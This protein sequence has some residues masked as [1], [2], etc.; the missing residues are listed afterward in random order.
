MEIVNV[1]L[2]ELKL[3]KIKEETPIFVTHSME[4]IQIFNLIRE[5]KNNIVMLENCSNEL[6]NDVIFFKSLHSILYIYNDLDIDFV[7][8]MSDDLKND[9][10]LFLYMLNRMKILDFRL[11]LNLFDIAKND[12]KNDKDVIL[13]ILEIDPYLYIKKSDDKKTNIG[14]Y[15]YTSENRFDEDSILIKWKKDLDILKL[16]LKKKIDLSEILT[17]EELDSS[18]LWLDLLNISQENERKIILSEY[19]KKEWLINGNVETRF[20]DNDINNNIYLNNII[21]KVEGKGFLIKELSKKECLGIDTIYHIIKNSDKYM[22]KKIIEAIPSYPKRRFFES[23]ITS[24]KDLRSDNYNKTMEDKD[25]VILKKVY[26]KQEEAFFKEEINKV[27]EKRGKKD[28]F[29]PFLLLREESD[30]LDLYRKE[31][32]KVLVDPKEMK[33]I[34]N[35]VE[36]FFLGLKKEVEDLES[37][38]KLQEKKVLEAKKKSKMGEGSEYIYPIEYSKRFQNKIKEIII[39]NNLIHNGFDISEFLLQEICLEHKFLG[40]NEEKIQVFFAIIKYNL[41]SVRDTNIMIDKYLKLNP[42]DFDNKER[43][44]IKSGSI[45]ISLK[46]YCYDLPKS[47]EDII[48]KYDINRK[49]ENKTIEQ[50]KDNISKSYNVVSNKDYQIDLYKHKITEEAINEVEVKKEIIGKYLK[51]KEKDSKI[52]SSLFPLNNSIEE[53]PLYRLNDEYFKLSDFKDIGLEKEKYTLKELLK[54]NFIFVEIM[55]NIDMVSDCVPKDFFKELEKSLKEKNG[56]INSKEYNKR[57]YFEYTK[58]I[59]KTLDVEKILE[60]GFEKEDLMEIEVYLTPNQVEK[61]DQYIQNQ[62]NKKKEVNKKIDISEYVEPNYEEILNTCNNMEDLIKVI[63][64]IQKEISNINN[65]KYS[66]DMEDMSN[67]IYEKEYNKVSKDYKEKKKI[68]L[69]KKVSVL[70]EQM[71]LYSKYNEH[72]GKDLEKAKILCIKIKEEI[73]VDL[74]E[75]KEKLELQI[76]NT[77]NI[78]RYKEYVEKLDS[79]ISDMLDLYN[80][81]EEEKLLNNDLDNKENNVLKIIEANKRIFEKEKIEKMKER[82]FSQLK[83][84]D[85][86]I[87]QS[88]SI[89]LDYNRNILNAEDVVNN[90]YNMFEIGVNNYLMYYEKGLISNVDNNGGVLD[91]YK[92]KEPYEYIESEMV[93]NIIKKL[94]GLMNKYQEELD[95]YKEK[96]RIKKEFK[97]DAKA[98]KSGRFY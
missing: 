75:E 47:F 49:N 17:K 12:L 64:V 33:K 31:M 11:F 13:K 32:S 91:I 37:G 25:I 90:V 65:V 82:M 3:K 59:I 68:L 46:E 23:V 77:E 96:K 93:V 18:A 30:F 71:A 28:F 8:Y 66:F 48:K 50:K 41:L 60:K 92:R 70:I 2:E 57:E 58:D 94:K 5:N 83:I 19:I 53:V 55:E 52:R 1:D 35:E 51:E 38:K 72:N 74:I 86:Q 6:K 45:D 88:S 95:N 67:M 80:K 40:I 63:E 76:K 61:I 39:E 7:K 26:K 22:E 62:T 29:E 4:H 9:K 43:L 81:Y 89:E 73:V 24:F 56:V 14:V 36:M 54:G 16:A 69:E 42:N 20:Y 87:L 10:D 21:R 15:T 78:K 44:K 84:L 98:F 85:T 79:V 34:K 97:E 27:F